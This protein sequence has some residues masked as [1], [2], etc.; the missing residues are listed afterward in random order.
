M[1]E[2]ADSWHGK[3][4]PKIWQLAGNRWVDL[5]ETSVSSFKSYRHR[6]IVFLIMA[7]LLTAHDA[8]WM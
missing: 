6:P 2:S 4:A 1:M 5:R 7:H 3:E 8:A